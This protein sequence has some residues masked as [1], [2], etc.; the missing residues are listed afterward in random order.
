VIVY[1]VSLLIET[2][3]KALASDNKILNAKVDKLTD[4]VQ[5]LSNEVLSLTK[6]KEF[7]INELD[8]KQKKIDKFE[9]EKN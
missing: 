5:E 6:D 7:L 9:K 2:K 4:K 3:A 1:I 8:R